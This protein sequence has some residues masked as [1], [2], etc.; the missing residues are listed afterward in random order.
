MA[1]AGVESLVRNSVDELGRYGIRVN[2]VRSG[3]V[4]TG[5]TA[6]LDLDAI[7][8]SPLSCNWMN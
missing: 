8:L 1:K 7:M 5:I 6:G 3:L 4:P 2:G